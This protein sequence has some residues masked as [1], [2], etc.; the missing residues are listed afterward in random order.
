MWNQLGYDRI[1]GA[2]ALEQPRQNQSGA[3][4]LDV[5]NRVLLCVPEPIDLI[6][7]CVEIGAIEATSATL[8][9]LEYWANASIAEIRLP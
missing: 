7:E 6:P 3:F 1:V 9:R 2:D 4:K 8:R 5:G